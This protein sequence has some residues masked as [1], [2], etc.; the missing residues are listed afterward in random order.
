MTQGE[1]DIEFRPGKYAIQA[2]KINAGYLGNLFGSRDNAP[3]NIA[4]FVL[5]ILIVA[6]I[7]AFF[8]GPSVP[9]LEFW[10]K[11][12]PLVTLVFGFLFGKKSSG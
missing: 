8:V 3:T 2:R 5:V 4:G 12:I 9:A 7:A 1:G 10:E 6:G 11:I